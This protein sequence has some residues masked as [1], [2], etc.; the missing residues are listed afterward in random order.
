MSRKRPTSDGGGI[1]LV[2]LNDSSSA[3]Q[4]EARVKAAQTYLSKDGRTEPEVFCLWCEAQDNDDNASSSN[5]NRLAR[6]YATLGCTRKFRRQRR[7]NNKISGNNDSFWKKMG[8]PGC[9]DCDLCNSRVKSTAL[10]QAAPRG[11]FRG[12]VGDER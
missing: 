10:L 1:E 4:V 3:H 2:K 5:N 8:C 11:L 9:C 6:F 7:R 12:E